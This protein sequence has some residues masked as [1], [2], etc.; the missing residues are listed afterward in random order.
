M[1]QPTVSTSHPPPAADH[2]SLPAHG[3]EET[4]PASTPAA[5]RSSLPADL[6]EETLPVAAPARATSSRKE[7]PMTDQ[8]SWDDVIRQGHLALTAAANGSLADEQ[9][10]EKEHSGGLWLD[11]P[12]PQHR[13]AFALCFAACRVLQAATGTGL[14]LR[15][16]HRAMA[17]L[18]DVVDRRGAAA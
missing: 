14:A 9:E 15:L 17:E 6:P 16:A 8:R 2:S 1:S 18:T 13:E 3:R 10:R 7:A 4:P 12:P 11:D 5:D